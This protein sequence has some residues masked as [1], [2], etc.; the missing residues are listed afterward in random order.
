MGHLEKIQC[1]FQGWESSETRDSRKI[2]LKR[3]AHVP[4]MTIS[5][6]AMRPG[7]KE[8]LLEKLEGVAT[9][10]CFSVE[11][12][13]V[14]WHARVAR[15]ISRDGTSRR[16]CKDLLASG[17]GAGDFELEGHGRPKMAFV[18]QRKDARESLG[19]AQD[20]LAEI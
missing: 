20:G 2:R 18:C 3:A 11:L 17:Y 13:H 9:S 16:L 12:Y 4:H 6:I 8:G 14:P 7:R 5:T 10:F 15:S 1:A 19:K